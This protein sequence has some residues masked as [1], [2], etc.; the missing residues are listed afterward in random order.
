MRRQ[1]YTITWTLCSA[2]AISCSSDSKFE[3]SFTIGSTREYSF[4]SIVVDDRMR[5]HSFSHY[6]PT[7]LEVLENPWIQWCV[8]LP[9]SIDDP[10]YVRVREVAAAALGALGLRNGMS[11]LEWFLRQDGS[12]AISEVGA[13]PPG[14]QFT[15]LLSYA[16]DLDF[17]V[18]W[19][20]LMATGHFEPPPRRWARNSAIP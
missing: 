11:H 9:R 3:N 6:Y 5:W 16:H 13:R 1:A 15:S 18:A 4:D 8:V 17:Y 12:V 2:A 19:G 7:P 14:A 10:L 20:R